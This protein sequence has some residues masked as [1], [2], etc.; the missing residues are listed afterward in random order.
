[1]KEA[2][3]WESLNGKVLCYLCPRNCKI[4]EGQN[5]FCNIRKNI[6]GKLYLIAHSKPC[7]VHIDPIE[8]KPLYHFFPGSDSFSIGT[9]GCNLA[10]KYCQNCDLSKA[11]QD[12]VRTFDLPPESAVKTAVEN[13]CESISYTYNEPIIW[14]EYAMD[15]SAIA[16]E[17]GIKSVMVTNGYINIEPLRQVYKYIDAA[18][19]DVKS[20]TEKF[21]NSLTLSHL[22]PVLDA[23]IE[24]K[25]MGVWIEVTNLVIPT[26]NDSKAEIKDLSKW[27]YDNLGDDVPVHFSAFHPDFR[28]LSVPRTSPETVITARNIAI[29]VGLKYVYTGNISSD[30]GS[31]TYCPSCGKILIDRTWH[32]VKIKKIVNGKCSCGAE[33]SGCF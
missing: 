27:V 20:I 18:N 12:Q 5:G 29:D 16:R 26:M 25:S 13:R 11:R 30:D 6:N 17:K 8:K 9:A 10:C 14:S 24:M 1:M 23:L 15:I 32:S 31:K 33:I 3:F 21:Y 2:L 19:V 22:K 28:F 7:A 4:G